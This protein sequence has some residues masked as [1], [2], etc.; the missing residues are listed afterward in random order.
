MN[1][2]ISRNEAREEK[3]H[4][5][6]SSSLTAFQWE[7]SNK[8]G[9]G[10]IPPDPGPTLVLCGRRCLGGLQRKKSPEDNQ[11]SVKMKVMITFGEVWH[12][13]GSLERK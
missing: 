8:Q 4:K 9:E 11:D 10:H 3:V 1:I 13:D 5:L 2:E 7:G 6:L 12:Q